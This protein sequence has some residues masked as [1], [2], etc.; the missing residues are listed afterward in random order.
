M[1]NATMS[2]TILGVITAAF[3][4]LSLLAL[5]EHGYVGIF[6]VQLTSLGGMQ[7]LADLVLAC[8]VLIWFMWRDARKS[9]RNIWPYFVLTLAAGSF[10]PLLYLLLRPAKNPAPADG[11]QI[12]PSSTA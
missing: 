4:V 1:E 10:G 12:R 5:R 7:V 11:A 8:A 2:K 3:A 9:G 6:A